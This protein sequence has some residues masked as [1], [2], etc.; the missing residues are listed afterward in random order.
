[1]RL[2]IALMCLTLSACA[3]PPPLSSTPPTPPSDAV[4]AGAV[5]AIFTASKLPGTPEVSPIRATA[6]TEPGDWMLCMKS[7]AADQPRR[8]AIFFA[9]NKHIDNRIAVAIDYCN[10]ATYAPRKK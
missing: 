6:L 2:R 7:S 5:T 3:S 10:T 1:V 8:Y 9:D 4:I